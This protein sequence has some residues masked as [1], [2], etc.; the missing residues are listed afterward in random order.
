MERKVERKLDEKDTERV[1][2]VKERKI[3]KETN[4]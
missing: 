2:H 1:K 4:L 3:K